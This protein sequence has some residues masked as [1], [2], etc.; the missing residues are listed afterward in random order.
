MKISLK[1]KIAFWWWQKSQYKK[2]EDTIQKISSLGKGIRSL[3][4]IFPRSSNQ[5]PLAQHFIKSI[6]SRGQFSAINKIICWQEQKNN[7]DEQFLQRVQFISE[8]DVNK[9]GLMTEEAIK[10]FT[11]GQFSCVINLDPIFNP[12]SYQLVS[13]FNS[14]IRI[15]FNSE[16]GDNIYNIIIDNNDSTNFIERG[17]EY[18]LEVLGL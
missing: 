13:S 3:L 12:V 4:I 15:G 5:L 6:L 14:I 1:T 7:I 18:L 8:D 17:Y 11:N 10:K 2:P 9:Y 16:N